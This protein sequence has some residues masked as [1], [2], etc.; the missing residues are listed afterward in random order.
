M[1]QFAFY[2]KLFFQLVLILTAEERIAVRYVARL[3]NYQIDGGT[4]TEQ[5]SMG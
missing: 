3:L 5:A 4:L 1:Y 2:L